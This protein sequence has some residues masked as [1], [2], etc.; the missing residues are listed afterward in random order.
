MCE[1]ILVRGAGVGLL[2][3]SDGWKVSVIVCCVFMCAVVATEYD[4]GGGA[5][6]QIRL[7]GTSSVRHETYINNSTMSTT[8]R[9]I[10]S[11]RLDFTN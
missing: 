6:L 5:V 4:G 3:L 10:A 2:V 1:S 8:H 11:Q 7:V 9:F